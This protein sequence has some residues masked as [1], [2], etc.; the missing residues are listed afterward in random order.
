MVCHVNGQ[1]GVITV[2]N[3][4]ETI[5]FNSVRRGAV[6]AVRGGLRTLEEDRASDI[7]RDRIT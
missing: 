6:S 4:L 7:S 2:C 5:V 3:E 1:D